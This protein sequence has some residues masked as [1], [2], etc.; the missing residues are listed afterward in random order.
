M[1][2]QATKQLRHCLQ[3][4]ENSGD[5]RIAGSTGQPENVGGTGTALDCGA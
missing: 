4:P 5:H 3:K 2:V 1:P